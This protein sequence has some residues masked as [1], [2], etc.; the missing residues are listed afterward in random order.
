MI[1]YPENHRIGS[2]EGGA[3]LFKIEDFK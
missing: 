3:F 1:F 2:T